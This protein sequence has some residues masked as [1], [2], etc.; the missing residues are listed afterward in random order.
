M[1]WGEVRG[2]G[3]GRGRGAA[4]AQ[5][6]RGAHLK[7]PAHVRDAGRV[8][9]QWLV[10]RLR[11]PSRKEGMRCGARCAG[12]AARAARELGLGA[13]AGESGAHA[14]DPTGGRLEGQ[15]TRAAGAP[16]TCCTCS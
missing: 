11:F 9:A 14:E 7:H 16:R 3:G 10:E 6:A 8:E 2:P 13:A 5:A 1:M 12:R 15:S 4:A